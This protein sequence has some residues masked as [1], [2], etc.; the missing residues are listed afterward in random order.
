MR[1]MRK[2]IAA[3]LVLAMCLCMM[4]A[5]PASAAPTVQEVIEKTKPGVM[6]LYVIG[7][8]EDGNPYKYITESGYVT[9][10]ACV[11]SGFCV[12]KSGESPEY[13]VTNWHV[14]ACHLTELVVDLDENGQLVPV[15]LQDVVFPSNRVRIWVM[16][17]NFTTIPGSIIPSEATAI[18]CDIVTISQTGYPDYAILKARRPL[19]EFIPLPI[20]SAKDVKEGDEVVALGC[21]GIIDNQSL[22]IGGSEI[23]PAPG[24][25][26]RHMTMSS[27]GNT[28][29]LLHD[30]RISG[31][32]SGGPLVNTKGQVI[33]LNTYDI[34][35]GRY[36]VAVYSDYV[37]EQLE[38]LKIPFETG[39]IFSDLSSNWIIIGAGAAVV[40][41]AV[42]FFVLSKKKPTS[43]PIRDDRNIAPDNTRPVH[44]PVNGGFR[45]QLPDGKVIPIGNSKVLVG[46]GSECKIRFPESESMISHRHCSLE[47]GGEYLIL[48]DEGSKNGT[49]IHG[50]KIPDGKKVALK[51]GS[52]FCVGS[53]KYRITVL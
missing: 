20:T 3:V 39:S 43:G 23:T 16:L 11:G 53:E 41:V 44:S 5:I 28:D 25:V 32:N 47:D 42:V 40:L 22:K 49:F 30:A 24:R 17:D 51:H 36:S 15:G 1:Y 37:I 2:R 6:K 18:E 10:A 50:K 13:I 14:A 38:Y 8:G 48:A 29:V 45:V 31:G 26:F 12:G 9:Y 33:G 21:P 52:S 7:Y 35:Q 19:K 4:L 46:R 34:E 27:A